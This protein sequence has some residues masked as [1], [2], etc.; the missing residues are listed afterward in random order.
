ML[1]LGDPGYELWHRFADGKACWGDHPVLS[2]WARVRGLR[3]TGGEYALDRPKSELGAEGRTGTSTLLAQGYDLLRIGAEELRRRGCA[4]VFTDAEGVLLAAFGV[5]TLPT[6]DLRESFQPGVLWTEQERGTNAIGTSLAE[7]APVAVIGRAHCDAN[8]HGLVCYAAPIHDVHGTVLAVL[9]ISGPVSA[10]DPML[11][12]TVQSMAGAFE[13]ILRAREIERL[14]AEVESLRTRE[15][16]VK[17][18]HDELASTLKLNETFV[19]TVGHDLRN[20][21]S[22]VLNGADLLLS[23]GEDPSQRLAAERI[24]SSGRRMFQMI[25]QLGDLA[26]TRLGGGIRLSHAP[27]DLG[28][29][30]ERVVSELRAVYPDRN[31]GL[32]RTGDSTGS[33]DGARMEQ[34]LSNLI[35]NAARHGAPSPGIRVM[36][37]GRRTHELTLSV[38]NAGEIEE[39][40]LPHLFKAFYSGRPGRRQ[41][42]GLGLGLGLYIVEQVVLAHNGHI[43]VVTKDGVTEFVVTLPRRP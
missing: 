41:S 1:T 5:D 6:R 37:D 36:L 42:E 39:E 28:V 38:A 18:A 4:L 16:E 29:V 32:V 22:A 9:D 21:L 34:V 13:G 17:S 30:A 14:A 2:R 20:P 11:G 19:A 12:I 40:A 35:S 7:D 24:R 31:I 10:A 3:T 26:R 25:D 43:D 33:W 27:M 15:A 8:S 23:K